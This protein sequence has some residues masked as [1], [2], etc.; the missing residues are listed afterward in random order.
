VIRWRCSGRCCSVRQ[1]LRAWT[2]AL[3]GVLL[4]LGAATRSE[5]VSDAVTGEQRVLVV[6]AT[7][8]PTPFEAADVRRVIFTEA[9]ALV[10]RASYGRVSLRGDVTSWLSVLQPSPECTDEWWAEGIPRSVSTPAQ[11]AAAARGFRL[12]NYDRFVYVMPSARCAF[13]GLGAGHEALLNGVLTPEL[14]VHELA[15]T[16]GLAHAG[17]AACIETCSLAE[18]GDYYSLMGVGSQDFTVPEKVRLGWL[19]PVGQTA[20]PG[21]Y[22]V[23]RADRASARPALR[24][25]TALGSY[26]IEYRPQRLDLG[27]RGVLPGGVTLRWVTDDAIDDPF[28]TASVLITNGTGRGRPPAVP[29]E[30]LRLPGVLTVRFVR[31]QGDDAVLRFQWNDRVAPRPPEVTQPSGFAPMGSVVRVRWDHPFERGSGVSSYRV[32]IDGA[33]AQVVREREL[34]LRDLAAGAHFVSV[35]AVDRAGNRGLATIRRFEVS[36]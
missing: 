21:T 15:H 12:A 10:R 5:A 33:R 26:W 6:L 8:G 18:D 19:R 14:V 4:A 1:V 22:R 27:R 20:R 9:D 28:A 2:V 35:S 7:W 13:I 25:P 17:A 11:A 30:T 16:W 34:V 24:I 3:A 23:T 32:S 36:R 29:G 31:R